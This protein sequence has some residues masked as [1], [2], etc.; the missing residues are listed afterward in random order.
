[1][2]QQNNLFKGIVH[3]KIRKLSSF[4]LLIVPIQTCVTLVLLWKTKEYILKNVFVHTL[5]RIVNR[6]QCCL[7]ANVHHSVFFCVLCKE[8]SLYQ[9]FIFKSILSFGACVICLMM[10]RGLQYWLLW[11]YGHSEAVFILFPSLSEKVLVAVQLL[12]GKG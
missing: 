11:L 5:N 6:I 7:D 9:P 2:M 4:T 12:A 8:D 10:L 3:Q 1:M